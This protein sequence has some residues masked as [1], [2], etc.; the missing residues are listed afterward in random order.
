[1]D[2]RSGLVAMLP[3]AGRHSYRRIYRG[4][5]EGDAAL[6]NLI[7]LGLV[8]HLNEMAALYERYHDILVQRI[9]G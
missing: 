3:V 8:E 9:E 2:D 1:M 7:D 4:A 6:Q 5:Q